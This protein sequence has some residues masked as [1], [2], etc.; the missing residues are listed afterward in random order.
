[1]TPRGSHFGLVISVISPGESFQ[2]RPKWL[3]PP[4]NSVRVRVRVRVRLGLWL[5]HSRT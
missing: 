4:S 1:M 5:D 2:P 3:P